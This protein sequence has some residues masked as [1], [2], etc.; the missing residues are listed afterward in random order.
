MRITSGKKRLWQA[1]ALLLAGCGLLLSGCQARPE[2]PVFNGVLTQSAPI[3]EVAL[4]Q[5]SDPTP[6]PVTGEVEA[7]AV[8][9]CLECHSDKDL[10][11]A[12]AKPEAP[13]AES[14]SK[15]VG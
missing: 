14:E 13:Q 9:E 3:G 11:I 7:A 5:G 10:L 4:A 15:G 12:N 8:N 6:E 2:M 1:G